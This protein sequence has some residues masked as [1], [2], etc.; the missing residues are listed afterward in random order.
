MIAFQLLG[1]DKIGQEHEYG[2]VFVKGAGMVG[3]RLSLCWI[4][5]LTRPQA[6]V[7]N[8]PDFTLCAI[9]AYNF[10]AKNVF[11]NSGHSPDFRKQALIQPFYQDSAPET[12]KKSKI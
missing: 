9:S 6:E 10:N 7:Q 2:K 4:C 1:N 11:P 3:G 12:N 5:D 8:I